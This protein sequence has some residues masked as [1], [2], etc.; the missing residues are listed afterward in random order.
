MR[1][2]EFRSGAY[3]YVPFSEIKSKHRPQEQSNAFASKLQQ[4]Q[5]M[6]LSLRSLS[7]HFHLQHPKSLA[8]FFS[9]SNKERKKA[10]RS[11]HWLYARAAT[12]PWMCLPR[13]KMLPHRAWHD[14]AVMHTRPTRALTPCA[15]I[16]D[17]DARFGALSARRWSDGLMEDNA[18]VAG[19]AV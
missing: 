19:Q 17:R 1:R 3:H 7:I 12:V 15:R 8:L 18:V 9:P 5:L 2:Y 13:S 10:E 4:W 11:T 16:R 6:V 14:F